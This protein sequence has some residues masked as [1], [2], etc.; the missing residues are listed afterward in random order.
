MKLAK[1]LLLGSAAALATVAGAQ[2][3]DLP[4]RK[5]APVAVEYVRVCSTYGA[6]FFVI[7]GTDSCIKIGGRARMDAV[8]QERFNRA[9]D[10]FGYRARGRLQA[11]VRTPTPYGLLRTFV[12]FQITADSGSTV[13]GGAAPRTGDPTHKPIVDQVFVQFGGLTAGRV[14]S[15]FSNP[16]LPTGH[17]GTL[18]FDDAADVSLFAYT[19]SF[20]NGFSATISAEDHWARRLS[21][22]PFNSTAFAGPDL[23][24]AITYQGARM[25]DVVGNIKYAGTW[26]TAQISGA[27]HE[28]SD[29][30]LAPTTALPAGRDADREIGFAVAGYLG[31]NLPMIA[32]GDAAWL[33]VTY[34]Q[35]ALQYLTGGGSITGNGTSNIG[36]DGNTP[37]FNQQGFGS[38]ATGGVPFVDA[39]IDNT[40]AGPGRLELTEAFSVAGG[41]RHYWIP[42]NLRSNL[43]GSW[44]H[45][46]HGGG[47]SF[48]RPAT[49]GPG[50]A[51][52]RFGFV[53]FDEYR[54]GGNLIWSPIGSGFDVGVEVIYKRFEFDGRVAVQRG[55]A[56]GGLPL[57]AETAVTRATDSEDAFEGRVRVQ[58]DF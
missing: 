6:G 33:A 51:G 15:F 29:L 31:V 52:T 18:R 2:A 38:N 5:A 30:G 17:M 43:F 21:G 44:L 28:V 50:F 25:P 57:G 56:V 58:R 3:A 10:Y 12:R 48:I 24:G 47:Q 55:G 37:F 53:D 22:G 9:Q 39:F 20:G 41:L 34:T 13:N 54:V 27:L 19:F 11:D 45:V 49:A 4:V 46:D 35:G 14:T 32:A 42:G 36:F 8:I 23:G 40:G 1:S 16:D 7:P 26:G